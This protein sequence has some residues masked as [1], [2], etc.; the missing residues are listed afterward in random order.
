MIDKPEGWRSRNKKGSI[1]QERKSA[2]NHYLGKRGKN[3]GRGKFELY[4]ASVGGRSAVV[5][6]EYDLKQTHAGSY[7]LAYG[8]MEVGEKLCSGQ[9][10]R[11]ALQIQFM[12]GEEVVGDYMVVGADLFDDL[13]RMADE[14][15]TLQRNKRD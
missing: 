13:V 10:K 3:S 2:D 6:I 11:F 1:D 14:K 5:N 12:E 15:A 8:Q 4:D 9:G 7:R